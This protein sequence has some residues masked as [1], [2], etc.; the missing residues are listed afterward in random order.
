MRILLIDDEEELVATLAERLTFR[1]FDVDW[2]TNARDAV[3]LVELHPYDVV[4]VDMKMPKTDGI[5]MRREL[6]KYRPCMEYLFMSGHG[7]AHSF[8][9]AVNVVGDSKYFLLK[10]V[11]IDVLVERIQSLVALKRGDLHG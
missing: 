6:E 8:R 5:E 2:A 11:D 9:E 3:G 4:V 1:G 7:S 10:P